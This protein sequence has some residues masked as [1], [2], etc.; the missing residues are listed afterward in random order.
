MSMGLNFERFAKCTGKVIFCAA[1]TGILSFAA[2]KSFATKCYHHYNHNAWHGKGM[3]IVFCLNSGGVSNPGS[4]SLP[5]VSCEA[6][7][8]NTGK[9]I[10][11]WRQHDNTDNGRQAFTD[12]NTTGAEVSAAMD[13]VCT[14]KNG[15][16]YTYYFPNSNAWGDPGVC[17]QGGGSIGDD[18]EC[19]NDHNPIL[20][21]TKAGKGKG[22]VTGYPVGDVKGKIDCSSGCNKDVAHYQ[23]Y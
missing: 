8:H 23:F 15:K 2:T 7:Y 19:V 1:A 10:S 18:S 6:R 20:T 9:K 14:G 5:M 11:D 4:F 12:Y 3:A 13:L 16:T 17:P 22:R 21:L